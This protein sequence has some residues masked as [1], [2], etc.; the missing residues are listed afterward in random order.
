VAYYN[1]QSTRR[2]KYF[3]LPSQKINMMPPPLDGPAS[4]ILA[5]SK[6]YNENSLFSS[7]LA[8]PD[9]D[10]IQTLFQNLTEDV[11]AVLETA[12]PDNS[13]QSRAS[14]QTAAL[15]QKL[16][17]EEQLCEMRMHSQ[18][19]PIDTLEILLAMRQKENKQY[20][21]KDYICE[22]D[23]L[24]HSLESSGGKI[25][26][27]WRQG[28]CQ[29]IQKC[30]AYF[31]HGRENLALAI[32]GTAISYLDRFLATL[33]PD[34]RLEDQTALLAALTAVHLARSLLCGASMSPGGILS[35]QDSASSH[36][37]QAIT[38]PF[39]RLL[40]LVENSSLTAADLRR[41]QGIMLRNLCFAVHPPLAQ[42]YLHCYNIL[43]HDFLRQGSIEQ[44]GLVD[45]M[46]ID[47]MQHQ[48]QILSECYMRTSFDLSS[49]PQ[50]GVS[51]VAMAVMMEYTY[52]LHDLEISD[53]C[54]DFLLYIGKEL[55][56]DF[57]LFL[58]VASWDSRGSR[59]AEASFDV[60]K[61]S[62]HSKNA[63]DTCADKSSDRCCPDIRLI[64]VLLWK[65]VLCQPAVEAVDSKCPERSDKPS[66][67]PVKSCLSPYSVA[68]PLRD[69]LPTERIGRTGTRTQECHAKTDGDDCKIEL[70]HVEWWEQYVAQ[71]KQ[72]IRSQDKAATGD[73]GQGMKPDPGLI[74][75]DIE[76]DVI[77]AFDSG[78]SDKGVKTRESPVHLHKRR[79]SSTFVC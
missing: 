61:R 18:A 74:I 56:L 60:S 51:L 12:I 58:K 33:A 5:S 70:S 2:I 27:G 38:L 77:T 73:R 19:C 71:F 40:Q 11:G 50:Y 49:M 10:E 53:L 42:E 59:T 17:G 45:P 69:F 16:A 29:W 4:K 35:S 31:S 63:D 13:S 22:D 6:V 62:V 64:R 32:E 21:F 57:S 37:R 36:S 26:A 48:A 46:I 41:T 78:S 52:H 47:Y 15:H 23:E 79:R 24:N 54:H 20:R 75:P 72:N 44:I 43:M 66:E 9:P 39:E 28:L 14:R 76:D 30:A 7:G 55:D 67:L 8:V 3:Q 34:T 1:S 25:P 65:I 68:A